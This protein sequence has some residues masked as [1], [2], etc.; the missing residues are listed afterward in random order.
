[1]CMHVGCTCVCMGGATCTE[2]L[3]AVCWVAW[4]CHMQCKCRVGCIGHRVCWAVRFCCCGV[5][6]GC[7]CLS[8]SVA[9]TAHG[10][11]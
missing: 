2:R 5:L 10:V 1:M 4:T 3:V 8:M 11:R 6:H 9:I 7:L